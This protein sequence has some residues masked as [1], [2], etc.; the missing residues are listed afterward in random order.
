[1]NYSII[2]EELNSYEHIVC[3]KDKNGIETLEGLY[4][5]EYQEGGNAILYFVETKEEAHA[6]MKEIVRFQQLIS[7]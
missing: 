5:Y 6:A 1:M 2:T 4:D 3:Y 7:H